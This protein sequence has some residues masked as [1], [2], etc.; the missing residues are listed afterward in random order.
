MMRAIILSCM[1]GILL[2]AALIVG[3]PV[4]DYSQYYQTET[5]QVGSKFIYTFNSPGTLH[6]TGSMQ[7]S[8]SPYWWL[9]AG[10]ELRINT[11]TGATMYGN[12]LL[13][14]NLWGLRYSLANPLDTDNGSHPQNLFRL[15]TKSTWEN[16]RQEM[17][18][19][20][21]SDNF[22]T[23]GNRNT[24]NGLLLMSRYGDNGQT[25]YYAG[26]RVDGTAVIKKKF[27]GTYY[28]M[29]QEKVFP[30]TYDG[31]QDSKN[32]IPHRQW[33]ILRTETITN[34]DG[35]VTVRLFKRMR[36]SA[37]EKLLEVTDS[38]QYAGT[39]PITGAG[40]S[41]VRT[42]FMDVRFE[43]YRTEEL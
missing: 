9:N 12:S 11:W 21:A 35:S 7:E 27:K 1:L 30:G 16:S 3:T 2:G 5:A 18:F 24:S 17:Q 29:A 37:W 36:D 8:T 4:L 15:L 40:H 39:Q 28:T 33:L 25:L 41:G 38:G 22:S 42:D 34:A 14:L 13:D 23:S 43:N 20:I 31:W 6:E 32:L 10:G 19:L 26:V